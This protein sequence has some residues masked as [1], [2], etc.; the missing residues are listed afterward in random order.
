MRDPFLKSFDD[1]VQKWFGD[2][3]ARLR[4]PF[5]KVKDGL[6][7]IKSRQFS[8]GIHG[9]RN[10]GSEVVDLNVALRSN[11]SKRTIGLPNIM[12]FYGDRVASKE[13]TAAPAAVDTELKRLAQ[14][15]S[16]Y[17]S[18]FL[19]GTSPDW[20]KITEFVEQKILDEGIRGAKYDLPK[21]VR[22]EWEVETSDD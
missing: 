5:A 4:L 8:L 14:L 2:L 15:A 7:E 22:E 16:K 19:C 11:E 20:S 6:F 1:S 12:D 9:S 10:H 21:F 18:P 13:L 17:C 3:A